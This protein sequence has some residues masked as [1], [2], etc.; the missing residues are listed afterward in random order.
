MAANFNLMLS[1]KIALSKKNICKKGGTPITFL[2]PKQARCMKELFSG[3]YVIGVLPTGYGKSLIFELLPYVYEALELAKL[4]KLA[5]HF[6]YFL[7]HPEHIIK[8]EVLDIFGSDG[9]Q[10]KNI[11]IVIDEAHCIVKWGPDFRPA[12]QELCR[13]KSVFPKAVQLAI[14]ATATIDLQQTELSRA[15]NMKNAMVITSPVDRPNIK[16]AV[17]TRLPSTG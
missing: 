2:K 3:R 8:K 13:L 12:F 4:Q 16:L 10:K 1:T 15:P 17:R 9:W 5:G 7:G 14:T 6:K 11:F